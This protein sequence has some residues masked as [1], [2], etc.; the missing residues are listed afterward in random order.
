MLVRQTQTLSVAVLFIA[1]SATNAVTESNEAPGGVKD[2]SLGSLKPRGTRRVIYNSDL[3]NTTSHMSEPAAKPEELRQV[4]RNYARAGG[5]DTLVQEIWHQGWSTFWRTDK[6]PYDSRPQ[7]RRLVPI[8]DTGI[9]PVEIYIDECHRQ[10]MEFLAG[11]RM[12]DRHGHNPDFFEKLSKEHPEWVLKEFKP[13]SRGAD[14]RSRALGSALDY[15]QAGVRDWLFP[16]MEEVATRFDVDGIEFNFTRMIQ[17][18]PSDKAA[19]SHAI[20]TGFV[21]RVRTMLKEASR[22]K[23]RKLLLGVRIPQSLAGCKK[24]GLDIPTW[25]RDRLIDYVAPGDIGFSDFNAKYEEFVRLAR[26]HDCYVYPQV[27]CRLGYDR[28]INSN[29]T[30]YQS[31]DQYRAILQNLYG[32][33]S[34]GF[35]TQNYFILWGGKLSKVPYPKTLNTLK[36]L[37]DP[38]MVAVGDR[39]YVFVPLWGPRGGPGRYY[40][41]ER[42]VLN[43][44]KVGDR[45]EFRFRMCEHLP[46]DP[47]LNGDEVVSGAMVMFKPGIVPGDKIAIDIN[48]TTIPAESIKYE[49][50]NEKGRPPLCTFVLGSPP[51]V[52]GDNYLGMKLVRSASGAAGDIV[53]DEVEVVVKAAE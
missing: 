35:S 34:D 13:T 39:H 48:G 4:V 19:Q 44:E 10:Q 3:S 26:A 11:F 14:P 29:R 45:G 47:K 9:M 7:H 25:I 24:W 12:N 18:F 28:W 37:R 46:A 41:P 30:D 8:M 2:A 17:C 23:G 36:V 21:R 22:K 27:E 15:S 5:I 33:G 6:C 20:M 16:I 52:Y 38:Q 51:A 31:P 1:V 40:R 49:W 43:R 42:I 32:A 50:Q 53:L